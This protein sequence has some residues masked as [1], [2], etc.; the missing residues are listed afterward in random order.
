MFLGFNE[1]IWNEHPF[2]VIYVKKANNYDDIDS[3]PGTEIEY[4]DIAQLNKSVG[5]GWKT[6]SLIWIQKAILSK[7]ITYA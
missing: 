1:N 5:Y 3:D 7:F 2:L 6:S 4:G